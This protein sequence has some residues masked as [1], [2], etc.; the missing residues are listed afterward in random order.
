MGNTVI[1]LPDN[2]NELKELVV[3]L[4]A[5]NSTLLKK[6][7]KLESENFLFRR[8]LFGRKSEKRAIIDSNQ[9]NLFNEIETDSDD[10]PVEKE[11]ITYVR[12]KKRGGKKVN[13]IGFAPE[14]PRKEIE[15]KLK[16]DQMLCSCGNCLREFFH[17]EHEELE[18]IEPKI[19]VRVH[20]YYNYICDACEKKEK[21]KEKLKPSYVAKSIIVA[22]PK[23]NR[24]LQGSKVSENT[25]AFILAAKFCDGLPFYRLEKILTRYNVK[26]LRSIMC[27]WAIR[28]YQNLRPFFGPLKK[29]L[30][31]CPVIGIDETRLRVLEVAGVK[32]KQ[33]CFMW[34]FYGYSKD[35]PIVLYH[36][37]PSRSSTVL[38]E[39]LKDY[40]GIIV[41]DDFEGYT[42]F[43]REHE[44]IH[45]LSNSH[46]RRKFV[47][48]YEEAGKSG[49]AKQYLD[50]Y[51]ELYKIED[52]IR[53][54]E[55]TPD[56][57][58]KYRQE[59]SKPIMDKMKSWLDE[60]YGAVLP[61]GNLGK[62]ISYS[63]T[64]WEKLIVFLE[65]GLI[66]IDNNM[67]ENAIRPFVI[68]RKNY[69]FAAV[70]R[71]AEAS[72][73]FYTLIE[74]AK[75]N[76]LEAYWYLRLLFNQFPNCSTVEEM[77]S[78]L[79]MNLK[80]EDLGNYKKECAS[81]E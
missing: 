76:G 77:E 78:L 53:K 43:S 42:K 45:A 28:G 37:A 23:P 15:H 57:I 26:I 52:D 60:R 27:N 13:E 24:L 81:E 65:N 17:R 69:L 20:K 7:I 12:T 9:V 67:T 6:V 36:Y 1:Q 44:L 40:K 46:A 71:G 56:E 3:N 2:P 50:W 14:L 74:T 33:N 35:G 75:A 64:N 5:E 49:E 34:V 79:P 21:E 41:S 47:T 31:E 61:Q 55:M 51:G 59:H 19:F 11:K 16:P 58:R 73:G 54:S 4:Q 25:L 48:A 66:P 62:A 70:D 39:F 18:I 68:G 30:L 22:G 8:E 38:E 29:K 10:T 72:A 32:R 63:Y 80:V